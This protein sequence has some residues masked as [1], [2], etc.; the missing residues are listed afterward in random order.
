MIYDNLHLNE[1]IWSNL[2]SS[3]ES[4]RLSHA[5]L[6]HGNKGI[7][8]EAHAIELAALI[9]CKSLTAN[10][11]C[12][13]CVSCKKIKSFQHENVKFIFPYPRGKITSSDDPSIKG[14]TERNIDQLRKMMTEKSQNPYARIKIENAN[15]ILINS[16]RE[17][18]KD[19]YMSNI[20]EGWKIIIIFDSEKLC[21]PYPTSANAL[22]KVL[23]EPP[24]KTI[25]ILVTSTLSSIMDTIKSRCQQLFFAPLST[26]IIK[27][28]IMLQGIP[29]EKAVVIA[30]IANGNIR[31]AKSLSE[32]IDE[33]FTDLKLMIKALYA[34]S[35]NEW[36][37]II[38]RASSLKRKDI[39]E[40]SYFFKISIL[41]FR[42]LE[43]AKHNSTSNYIFSNLNNHYDK[44]KIKYSNSNWNECIN[45]LE[46]TFTNIKM[47]GF[48][49]LNILTMLI[50]T[51]KQIEGKQIKD[52]DIH[53]W[54][55]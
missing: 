49:P 17:L 11:A 9:N 22:L 29:K 33:L 3:F 53:N 24:E 40:L 16:I 31:L 13:D 54:T 48:L 28:K 10:R 47:N 27:E 55:Q 46:N 4:K 37:A 5:F 12:G 15:T 39:D 32:N 41:Y 7:G 52:L 42:D 35:Q 44:I 1:S 21:T 45:I 36:K 14:L 23:E 18:K 20:D 34:P 8:K 43:L 25:F 26:K 50:A 30:N 2:L 38:N 19:I 6:F 51:K